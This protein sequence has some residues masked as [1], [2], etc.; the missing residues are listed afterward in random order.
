MERITRPANR[1]RGFAEQ[2][3]LSE[4]PTI[5]GSELARHAVPQKMIHRTDGGSLHLLVESA[6]A[7]EI[8][9]SE[10]LI[11][12]RIASFFGHRAVSRLVLHQ[13]PVPATTPRAVEEA[14]VAPLPDTPLFASHEDGPLKETLR[15]LGARI[16]Q[17]TDT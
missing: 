15:R 10:A 7:T 9:Y 3:L 14:P 4:W 6:W 1:K 8:Q 17:R 12:E 2:R 11:L 13:G 5:V 16:K